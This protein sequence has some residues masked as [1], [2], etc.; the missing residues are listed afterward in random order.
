MHLPC[1]CDLAV[2]GQIANRQA[3]LSKTATSLRK[4]LDVGRYSCFVLSIVGATL[5]AVASG[6]AGEEYRDYLIWP[7]TVMLALSAFISSRLLGQNSVGMHVKA[8]L[9]SESLKREAYLY[10][11]RSTNYKDVN[12]RE[13]RLFE[14][15]TRI[16]NHVATL[17]SV[18]R[19]TTA[20][21][22]CPRQFMSLD[23]YV[24]ERI[25]KE[26]KYYRN[27]ADRSSR[28]SRTFHGVELALAASATVVTAVAGVSDKGG[29]DVAA[30]TAVLTTLTGI[31][32]THIHAS[33]CDDQ[34][35]SYRVT[36]NRLEAYKATITSL[37]PKSDV[38]ERVEEILSNETN[39]W[40]TLWL[41]KA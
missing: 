24:S 20:Q 13:Q 41:D 10:A 7:A 4:G 1:T 33:R 22:S 5:A 19:S 32:V 11:T 36:A 17:A 12:G 6:L 31:V 25:V 8:R 35:S 27:S 37:V 18:E 28:L 26:I 9:A 14:A 23:Q 3:V 30:L 15:L 38:V 16:D 34:T 40:Q 21:G 29:F 2:L 39:S